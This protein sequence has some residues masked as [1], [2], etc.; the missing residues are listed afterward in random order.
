MYVRNY[1]ITIYITLYK[2]GRRGKHTSQLNNKLAVLVYIAVRNG[3]G[4][5]RGEGELGLYTD[6][7]YQQG[8]LHFV[9]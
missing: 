5:G 1:I 6:L 2:A 9:K 8:R 7:P 3:G 4:E